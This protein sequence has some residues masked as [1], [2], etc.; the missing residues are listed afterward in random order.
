MTPGPLQLIIILVI[1][2]LLFGRGRIASIMGDIGKGV[3]AMRE[4]LKGEEGEKTDS[5]KQLDKKDD[6]NTTQS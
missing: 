5:A 1:V 4:G 2:L 3:R 6:T